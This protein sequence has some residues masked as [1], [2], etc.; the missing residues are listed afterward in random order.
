MNMRLNAL[1]CAGLACM[2]LAGCGI[3]PSNVEAPSGAE[4]DHFPHTYPNPAYDPGASPQ[5]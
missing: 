2:L 3:K 1:I 4:N 5:N